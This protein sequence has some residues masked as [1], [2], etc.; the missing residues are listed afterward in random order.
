M[1]TYTHTT[2]DG[3]ELTVL[4]NGKYMFAYVY[5]ENSFVTLQFSQ[6]KGLGVDE[7]NGIID[8]IDFSAIG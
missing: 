6:L 2:P 4:H 3:T 5:L 8:M 1:S 7:I